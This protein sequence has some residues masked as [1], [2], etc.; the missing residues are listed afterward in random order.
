MFGDPRLMTSEIS[1]RHLVIGAHDV[2]IGTD[3]LLDDLLREARFAIEST[4][5]SLSNSGAQRSLFFNAG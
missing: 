3:A 4:Y 2:E 1:L 5:G